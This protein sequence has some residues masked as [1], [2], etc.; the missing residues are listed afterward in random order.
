MVIENLLVVQKIKTY[1]LSL[2]WIQLTSKSI[3]MVTKTLQDLERFRG[4]LHLQA[5]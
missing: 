4:W 5:E 1:V 2:D 3:T